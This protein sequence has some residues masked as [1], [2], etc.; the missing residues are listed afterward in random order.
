MTYIESL[1]RGQGLG[2]IE[3]EQSYMRQAY[4]QFVSKE[5]GWLHFRS[6]DDQRKIIIKENAL[7]IIF[8]S[9]DNKNN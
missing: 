7:N 3:Y 8:T 5:R 6:T 2:L 4:N 1:C 9:S